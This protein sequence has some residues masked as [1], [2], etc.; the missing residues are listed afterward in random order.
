MNKI[1][2]LFVKNLASSVSLNKI[3]S[4]H[5]LKLIENVCE[6]IFE[7]SKYQINNKQLHKISNHPNI[8]L[9]RK[10][11]QIVKKKKK[12]NYVINYNTE[13][14]NKLFQQIYQY[15]DKAIVLLPEF[16]PNGLL[17]LLYAI[18]KIQ[19]FEK[20]KRRKIVT[21]KYIEYYLLQ[22][23][24]NDKIYNFWKNAT[25]ND[26]ILLFKMFVLNNYF[27]Y[28]LLSMLVQKIINNIKYAICSDLILFLNAYHIYIKRKKKIQNYKL[29]EVSL[30]L[31]FLTLMYENIVNSIYLISNKELCNFIVVYSIYGKNNTMLNQRV[32]IYK[33]LVTY[34]EKT[35][36]AYSP[37]QLI[38]IIISFFK[39]Y[40]F[41]FEK[42]NNDNSSITSNNNKI[43]Q[44]HHNN[45]LKQFFNTYNNENI[46]VRIK[47]QLEVLDTSIKNNYYDYD[48]LE[49]ILFNIKNN[50]S[51]L[52][53][54]NKIKFIKLVIKL[55]N[56]YNI[57]EIIKLSVPEYKIKFIIC[58]L[59]QILNDSISFLNFKYKIL[60]WNFK[61]VFLKHHIFYINQ[62]NTQ[63]NV[64]ELTV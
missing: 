53:D 22:H 44:L 24:V 15:I 19:K 29:K 16:G 11:R 14:S 26:T 45:F 61:T 21:F 25:T 51:N 50:I 31:H 60:P 62:K 10:E 27:S 58:M 6:H 28:E 4:T 49:Y 12:K 23:S 32:E 52:S 5:L 40:N 1:S 7:I 47:R 59:T 18:L 17:R 43:N 30:P 34:I 36:F 63:S 38:T 13:N 9:K 33:K 37:E 35:I 54:K 3:N 8:L 20:N 46:D 57:N 2:S 42:N 41:T 64:H 48:T 56:V 39:I 55:R